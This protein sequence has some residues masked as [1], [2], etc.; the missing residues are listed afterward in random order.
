MASTLTR[1]ES[2]V[3]LAELRANAQPVRPE[4]L[5]RDR[6]GLSAKL[7]RL[8]S[9]GR[10][11]CD[12]SGCAHTVHRRSVVSCSPCRALRVSGSAETTVLLNRS[13][14]VARID[15]SVW[16]G[17][18][19]VRGCGLC[20]LYRRT[21]DRPITEIILSIIAPYVQLATDGKEPSLFPFSEAIAA[22]ISKA[23]GVAH[24]AMHRPGR[25][26]SVKEAAWAVMD[27]AYVVA[28]GGERKLPANARQIMYAARPAILQL[29]GKQKLDDAY[30]TQKLLP[31][32]VAENGKEGEW[33]VVFDARGTFVEPHTGHE[34]RL[35]TI[36]V[37]NYVARQDDAV[38]ERCQSET[39]HEGDDITADALVQGV[40]C[41]RF[42][43]M[44]PKHRYAAV[45]FIEKEGFA[46]LLRAARIAE[47]FDIAIMSTK[48][49]STTA[50]R[51]LLDEIA[52]QIDKVLVLHDFDVAGFSIF[53][54]LGADGRRY[55]FKNNLPIVDI[56]LRLSDVGRLDLQSEAVAV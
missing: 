11:H 15:A 18:L 5:G 38:R 54:T 8:C 14:T 1:E 24:R 16:P 53:G 52:G 4:Q 25:T 48:G 42:P 6:T 26:L 51:Q 56:G 21:S 17:K 22:V 3:V 34:V 47:R 32:Y 49:M 37:R 13:M 20:R 10:C 19:M 33:D 35:G 30:F 7:G 45:L 50:A 39:Q 36:D 43:T 41:P 23:C 12:A 55:T 44:G 29:T 28:S 9:Q 40:H 46:P 31:D 2:D 27:K